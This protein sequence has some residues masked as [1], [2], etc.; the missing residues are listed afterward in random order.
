[1]KLESFLTH[2][3]GLA[4]F[5]FS[6]NDETKNLAYYYGSL[7]DANVNITHKIYNGISL[8]RHNTNIYLGTIFNTF[9]F[10]NFDLNVILT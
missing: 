9:L 1:M 8:F 4:I 3:E 10:L 7:K 5:C 2:A 6:A